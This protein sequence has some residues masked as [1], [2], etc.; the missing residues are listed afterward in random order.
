M[1]MWFTVTSV[2]LKAR[3]ILLF[4]TGLKKKVFNRTSLPNV[5]FD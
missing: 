4:V 3:W 5:D 1:G 2:L